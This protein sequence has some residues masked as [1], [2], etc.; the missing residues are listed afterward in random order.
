M[1]S[2][3]AI[4]GFCLLMCSFNGQSQ[5]FGIEVNGG[6]LG[7]RFDNPGGSQSKPQAGGGVGV[8]YIFPLSAHFGLLTGIGGGYYNTKTTLHNDAAFSSWQVDNTGS[9][10]QYNISTAGYSEKQCFLA[11]A[12]PVMLHYHTVG[13]N[14]QWY[15]NAGTKFILPFNEKIKATAQQ[16]NLSGYYP[17]YNV[18]VFNVPQ[19]G[20][21][22]INNWQSSR[23]IELKPTA[24]LSGSTGISFKLGERMHLYT[25]VYIDMGLTDMKKADSYNSLIGYNS[26][27]SVNPPAGGVF[28][29]GNTGD[30]KLFACGL[31]VKLGL[32]HKKRKPVQQPSAE[33]VKE[34]AQQVTA[35][36]ATPQ[37]Q[38][39]QVVQEEI[40]QAPPPVN[41]AMREADSSVFK[42]PVTFGV[43]GQTTIPET[44]YP[45]LDSMVVIL[46]KYS[47]THLEIVGHTCNI[48]SEN[49]NIKVG[50]ER[51]KAVA[52]YL[53]SKGIAAERMHL[54]SAG[55]SDPIV[56]NSSA[57]NRQVN[58]RVTIILK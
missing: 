11:A 13:N 17:D 46:N 21:A 18:E 37:E 55:L 23:S 42:Q 28:S 29:V 34:V 20:F 35:Q 36:P 30:A 33:P 48:G 31:Q 24:T 22:A 26:A 44:A 54:R 53:Q 4:I 40:V 32:E 15:L 50:E 12:I 57:N 2:K 41:Q 47:A 39:K 45:H 8:Q 56:P 9:A 7:L 19:H 51:A 27:G 1:T 10:F 25:G 16:L 52:A 58:R 38:S 5:E 14:T 3:I 6:M 43:L 49:E